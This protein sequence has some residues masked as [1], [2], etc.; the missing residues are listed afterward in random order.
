M[1][2]WSSPECHRT[3]CQ[4]DAATIT[5]PPH[6]TSNTLYSNAYRKAQSL[7]LNVAETQ[8]R[9]RTAVH[10]WIDTGKIAVEL[11]C[12]FHKPKAK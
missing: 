10:Q 4:D 9:A 11:V 5:P 12:K 7:G 3:F 6:V 1:I 2:V 8:E